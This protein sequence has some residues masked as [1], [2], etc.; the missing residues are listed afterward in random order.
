MQR[1]CA[2]I[3]AT[4]SRYVAAMK[5]VSGRYVGAFVALA[6]VVACSGATVKR[7]TDPVPYNEW[8]STVCDRRSSAT[9]PKCGAP[10][11]DAAPCTSSCGR[12]RGAKPSQRT[13]DEA[14]TWTALSDSLSCEELGFALGQATLGMGSYSERCTAR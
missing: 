8:C 12:G 13:Y 3:R 5:T 9:E 11:L 1:R 4:Q 7:G 14:K 2:L 10:I 6:G